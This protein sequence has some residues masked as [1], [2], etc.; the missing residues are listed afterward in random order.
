MDITN[1]PSR[2]SKNE[3][4]ESIL[5][6]F[7]ERATMI[8][9]LQLVILPTV[10]RVDWIGCESEY[11]ELSWIGLDWIRSLSCWIGLDWILKMDPVSNSAPNILNSY[12]EPESGKNSELA[13]AR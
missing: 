6:V 2:I 5:V 3:S 7:N 4:F 9:F 13:I 1:G 11:T 8:Q 10:C 12:H